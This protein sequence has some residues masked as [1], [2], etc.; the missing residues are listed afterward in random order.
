MIKYMTLWIRL[1]NSL[2]AKKHY[3]VSLHKSRSGFTAYSFGSTKTQL[4]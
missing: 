4:G 3:R 1:R 2:N